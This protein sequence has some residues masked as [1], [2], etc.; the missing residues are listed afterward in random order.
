MS[1]DYSDLLKGKI[2][3]VDSIWRVK[4]LWVWFWTC[5]VKHLIRVEVLNK[6]VDISIWNLENKSVLEVL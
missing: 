4:R 2:V 6:Q 1:S 3:G 5:L